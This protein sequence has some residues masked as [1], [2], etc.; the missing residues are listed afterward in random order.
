MIRNILDDLFVSILLLPLFYVLVTQTIFAIDDKA[1]TLT[2]YDVSHTQ[3][4]AAVQ[5]P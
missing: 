2:S 3:T 4:I 1:S 5:H